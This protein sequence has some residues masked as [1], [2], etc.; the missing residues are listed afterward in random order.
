MGCKENQMN[1]LVTGGGGF[2]GSALVHELVKTGYNVTSFS[3]SDYP[4]L[5]EI[6]VAVKRGDLSDREAVLN[7]CEGI[8]IVFH[9]AAKAGYWGS[10]KDYYE[11]NVRGTVNIINACR[12][13]KIKWL[14]FTSSASVIFGGTDIEGL[15]ES[16]PY[17]SRPLSDY[18][19][20]KALAEQYVLKANC[21]SLRTLAL[22]PHIVLGPGDKHIIPRVLA[23]AREGKLL[24]IGDGN[25][26]TDI[27]YIDNVVSAHLCSA[28]A[29]MN[30]PEVSGK[31]YFI[32][33]G[34][35]VVIWEYINTILKKAGLESI[36][37]SVPVRA[38]FIYAALTE[39]FHIIFIIRKEPRLTRFLVH[40]L[41]QS[42]WFNI[43]SARKL[44]GYNPGISNM[45]G[46][47]KLIEALPKPG[48]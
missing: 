30:N 28:K 26:K 48:R 33:N 3:R 27:S 29:I 40:E 17:P 6:G 36:N 1:A 46:L 18:T 16:L 25:N 11:T 10:Y 4:E 38:A 7:S 31:A 20:T 5:R 14:I 35:P 13:K 43:N 39:L 42:H 21:S 32:S 12:E 2:I 34:E 22:R 19:A 15:D 23:Q 8:D 41:S 37:K 24:Q 9:V 47:K 45:E 44:L